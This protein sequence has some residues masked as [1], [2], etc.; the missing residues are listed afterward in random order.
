MHLSTRNHSWV[1]FKGFAEAYNDKFSVKKE[2]GEVCMRI[3]L[4]EYV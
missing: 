1:S 3:M 2:R 4:F